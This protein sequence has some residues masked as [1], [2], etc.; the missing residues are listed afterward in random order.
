MKGAV[1]TNPYSHRRM[2]EAIETALAMPPDQ[3]RSRMASMVEAVEKLS[4]ENWAGEQLQAIQQPEP[5][6]IG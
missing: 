3:Q 1:L 4:V 2:D 5:Q 6:L